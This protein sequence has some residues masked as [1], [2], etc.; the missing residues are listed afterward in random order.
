MLFIVCLRAQYRNINAGIAER[1]NSVVEHAGVVISVKVLPKFA[2]LFQ[3]RWLH[4]PKVPN[5]PHR[6]RLALDIV[7]GRASATDDAY[8]GGNIVSRRAWRTTI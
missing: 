5:V 2:Q 8:G 7:R 3:N 1:D 4:A 6:M